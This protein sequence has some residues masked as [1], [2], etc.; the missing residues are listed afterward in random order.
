MRTNWF[1][2]L[3]IGIVA[4]ALILPTVEK[5]LARDHVDLNGIITDFIESAK[6]A[7]SRQVDNN[8]PSPE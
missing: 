4:I 5:S 8:E 7:V 3:I 1:E 2:A 6:E